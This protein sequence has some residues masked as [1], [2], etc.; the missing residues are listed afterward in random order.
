MTILDGLNSKQKEQY[1]SNRELD[2]SYQLA[3]GERFRVNLHFEKGNPGLVA[4]II[5]TKIPTMNIGN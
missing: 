5:S 2:A 3:S 4:R 1:L